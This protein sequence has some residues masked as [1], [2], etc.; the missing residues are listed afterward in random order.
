MK[1][2]ELFD[3]EAEQKAVPDSHQK[4]K[5]PEWMPL[6]LH[7]IQAPLILWPGWE[8]DFKD[9]ARE[10]VTKRLIKIAQGNRS[11]EATDFEVCMYCSSASLSR[12]PG[13]EEFNIYAYAFRK[14]FGEE[15]ASSIFG[16]EG[17]TLY[18][19]E[20]AIYERLKEWIY[21]EQEKFLKLKSKG[22]TF[23]DDRGISYEGGAEE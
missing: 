7:A 11:R 13:R 5:E 10:A 22:K 19:D 4:E 21:R 14:E 6:V 20:K 8:E 9:K 17:R 18:P 3:F 23:R 1:S 12:P 16:D 2:T 15:L